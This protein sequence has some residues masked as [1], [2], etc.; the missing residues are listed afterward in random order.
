MEQFLIFYSPHLGSTSAKI[1]N[2]IIVCKQETKDKRQ[3]TKTKGLKSCWTE[4]SFLSTLIF[5]PRVVQ[6]SQWEKSRI[7][8]LDWFLYLEKK[9]EGA[10]IFTEEEQVH[11]ISSF[12][13]FRFHSNAEFE[14]LP[15]LRPFYIWQKEKLGSINFMKIFGSLFSDWYH[16]FIFIK[17]PFILI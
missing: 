16:D 11:L 9:L 17:N 10:V 4:F 3:K 2:I 8:L 6:G 13:K 7:F 5:K 1:S 12:R 15:K 14:F